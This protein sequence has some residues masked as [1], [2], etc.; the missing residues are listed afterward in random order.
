MAETAAKNKPVHIKAAL[1]VD[2]QIEHLKSK[3]IKFEMCGEDDAREYLSSKCNLFKV[4]SYRKLFSK[5]VGGE[6]DGKY[7]E[8]D[9]GQLKLL[10]SID[11]SMRGILRTLALDIEHFQKV[12]LLSKMEQQ[13][14]DEDGYSIVA[15]YL[16]SLSPKDRAYKDG[17][18]ER[19]GYSSYSKAI[20]R[21]YQNDLPIWVFLE[22]ISF[23]TLVDFTMFCGKRWNDKTLTDSY[24][25]LKRVKSVRNGTSHGSCII[26]SFAD[27]PTRVCNTS[28]EVL[29]AVAASGASKNTRQK[30]MKNTPVRE[31]AI[32]LVRY[33]LTVPE[34]K[35]KERAKAAL[36]A[37]FDEVGATRGTLPH[38]GH[39]STA[40]AALNYLRGLTKSLNLLD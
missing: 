23:G 8:L 37:F 29:S 40:V 4:A 14:E 36:A 32:T 15:D 19:C 7:V 10:A 13:G 22:M 6:N 30:W 21:K 27:S 3:G 33:N 20:Y 25:D 1:D 28:S 26:N 39:G 5:Y 12:A 17:E 11:N 31:I 18:L 34:G 2:R 38:T 16:N 35:S 9:F 24:Y